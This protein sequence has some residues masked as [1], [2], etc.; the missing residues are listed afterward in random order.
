ME[1]WPIFSWSF[2]SH[3]HGP[4]LRPAP[5]VWSGYD[6]KVKGNAWFSAFAPSYFRQPGF[7][8][9]FRETTSVGQRMK[10]LRHGSIIVRMAAARM[11]LRSQ[12][13]WVGCFSTP[14][15]R[16]LDQQVPPINRRRQ[17]STCTSQGCWPW[18]NCSLWQSLLKTNAVLPVAWIMTNII[19]STAFL[20]PSC[21]CFLPRFYLM[22]WMLPHC[23]TS[24][25]FLGTKAKEVAEPAWL[26]PVLNCPRIL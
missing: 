15:H 8:T 5:Q 23:S 6:M 12:T 1:Q 11:K 20:W 7:L 26:A 19:N 14:Y 4:S 18:I 21:K 9:F 22:V 10:T 24:H 2:I 3:L 17:N 16:T 13:V 25:L